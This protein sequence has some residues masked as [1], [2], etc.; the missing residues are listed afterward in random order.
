MIHKLFS[1]KDDATG[2]FSAPIPFYGETADIMARRWYR[3]RQK[4]DLKSISE[5]TSLWFIG[6]WDNKTGDIICTAKDITLLE[7][8]QKYEDSD[9]A[10]IQNIL[11]LLRDRK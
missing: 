4:E 9:S 7:R 3:E 8:G 2:L 6:T 10:K 11:E 5:D 1:I